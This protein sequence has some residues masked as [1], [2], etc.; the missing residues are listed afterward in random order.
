MS[1]QRRIFLVGL[2]GLIAGLFI[3]FCFPQEPEKNT[4]AQLRM[5]A[6]DDAS[7][8]LLRQIMEVA[9]QEGILDEEAA[10]SQAVMES[11]EFKDC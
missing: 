6:G 4:M 7:G 2:L 11:F 10:G 3:Q 8:L 9:Q 1:I 5:G